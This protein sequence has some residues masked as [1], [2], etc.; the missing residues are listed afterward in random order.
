MSTILLQTVHGSTLYNINHADSDLDTYTVVSDKLVKTTQSIVGDV[1]SLVIGY[2]RFLSLCSKGVPQALEALYSPVPTIDVF[3]SMRHSF[4]AK[5]Y[6]VADTYRRTIK[7]FWEH[8]KYG[9]T[10]KKRRH[11]LRLMLNL[12]DIS[13]YGQFNPRLSEEQV[14]IITCLAVQE[15]GR[16]VL[17]RYLYDNQTP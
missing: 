2:D 1:D 17:E 5:S 8:P 14:E 10:F 9:G 4:N 11:A 6:I 7:N 15:D 13:K 16:E 12:N 3:P